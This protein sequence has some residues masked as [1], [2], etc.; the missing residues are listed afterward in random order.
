[1]I[2]KAHRANTLLGWLTLTLLTLVSSITDG[3]AINDTV[4]LSVIGPQVGNFAPLLYFRDGQFKGQLINQVRCAF[5]ASQI[6]TR[7][8][9]IP[10]GR[11]TLEMNTDNADGYFPAT[12]YENIDARQLSRPL[13]LSQIAI[14][15]WGTVD[16]AAT[17]RP[18]VAIV[19]RA[20]ATEQLVN[21]YQLP[22]IK[23]TSYKQLIELLLKKRVDAVIANTR[24]IELVAA[25]GGYNL[26][27]HK[28][29]L[30]TVALMVYLTPRFTQAH[31]G[32][33]A[34]FNQHLTPCDITQQQR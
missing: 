13:L 19:R 11:Q 7:F 25:N 23:T 8:I 20:V 22:V 10:V 4:R 28:Q 2:K 21:H 32:I 29:V 33:I 1:M 26:N 16:L 34:D 6:Q 14:Y 12:S 27:W 15:S 17:P 30:N 18:R 9:A 31:P 5:A 3:K 24:G